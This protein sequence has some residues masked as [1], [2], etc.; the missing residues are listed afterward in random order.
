[1]SQ[2]T[3]DFLLSGT[4]SR[5]CQLDGLLDYKNYRSGVRI[6][7]WNLTM[8]LRRKRIFYYIWLYLIVL[9]TM[10]VVLAVLRYID[11]TPVK[12][13]HRYFHSENLAALGE[14]FAALEENFTAKISQRAAAWYTAARQPFFYYPNNVARSIYSIEISGIFIRVLANPRYLSANTSLLKYMTC[15]AM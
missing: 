13:S 6:I 15:I 9:Q 7:T 10:P 12:K 4:Q 1:M 2:I 5:S 11:N 8:W 14:N 3:S